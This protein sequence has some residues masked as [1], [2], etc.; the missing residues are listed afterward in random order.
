MQCH[1]M[2]MRW[3][4]HWCKTPH[5]VEATDLDDPDRPILGIGQHAYQSKRGMG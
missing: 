1:T 4:Q 5:K 3:Q 2:T